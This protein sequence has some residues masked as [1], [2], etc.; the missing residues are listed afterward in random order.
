MEVLIDLGIVA[1]IPIMMYRG[2]RRGGIVT[3]MSFFTIFVAFIGATFLSYNFCEPVGRLVQPVVKTA[4]TEALETALAH[5]EISIEPPAIVVNESGEQIESTE[6]YLSLSRAL[7]LL[8]T[9]AGIEKIDGFLNSAKD[10]LMFVAIDY[11]GSATDAIST[12]VGREIARVAIFFVSF[13]LIMAIWLLATRAVNF[14]FKVAGVAQIN[15]IAGAGIGF[16]TAILLVYVFAWATRGTL[17]SWDG[18]NRTFLYQHFAYYT[19]LDLIADHYT[20]ELDL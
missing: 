6:T 15:A 9:T 2:F 12:V 18:V 16:L 11:K 5:E 13:L 14:V 20:I 8:T 17:V 1:F 7:Q 3:L 19:P 4:I 10:S